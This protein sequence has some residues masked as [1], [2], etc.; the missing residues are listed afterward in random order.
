MLVEHAVY[1]LG[2]G[3]LLM[4]KFFIVCKISNLD[5]GFSISYVLWSIYLH[6]N[7]AKIAQLFLDGACL[8]HRGFCKSL[9]NF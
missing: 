9:Q 6:M 1:P 5:I 8:R 7:L 3:D 2:P 4:F